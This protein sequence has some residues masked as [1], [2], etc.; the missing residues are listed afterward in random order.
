MTGYIF[1]AHDEEETVKFLQGQLHYDELEKYIIVEDDD[2]EYYETRLF[3][4]I[5]VECNLLIDKYE[6]E[7]LECNEIPKAIEIVEILLN[8]SDEQKF[9]GFTK[10]LLELFTYAKENGKDVEF[11]F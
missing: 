9:I 6:E 10:R 3:D 7:T 11:K 4:F 5:N 1:V 8:N 2:F